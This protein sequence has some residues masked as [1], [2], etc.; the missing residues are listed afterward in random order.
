MAR[1]EMTERELLQSALR[2]LQRVGVPDSRA[3]SDTVSTSGGSRGGGS[4][5]SPMTDEQYKAAQKALKEKV[6]WSKGFWGSMKDAGGTALKVLSV[7]Q[8]AAFTGATKLGHAMDPHNVKD[9]SWKGMAGSFYDGYKGGAGVLD[10]YGVTNPKVLRWGGL[11]M[12][13]VADPMWLVGAGALSKIN[14]AKKAA[15][16][17]NVGRSAVKLDK[18][19]LYHDGDTLIRETL[20]PAH[21]GAAEQKADKLVLKF[22]T[23][24][25][26][27]T[28]PI[29]NLK[30]QKITPENSGKPGVFRKNRAEKGSYA[31]QRSAEEMGSF[32][33]GQ[34]PALRKHFNMTEQEAAK[35][36]MVASTGHTPTEQLLHVERA[37]KDGILPK[38]A[39]DAFE[40]VVK[41]GEEASAGRGYKSREA[42]I[43]EKNAEKANLQKTQYDPAT[44]KAERLK[45]ADAVSKLQSEIAGLVSSPFYMH[46]G[47]TREALEEAS[48]SAG[49]AKKLLHKVGRRGGAEKAASR[50][51]DVG[52]ARSQENMFNWLTRPQYEA[53]AKRLGLSADEAAWIADRAEAG[54]M[55]A[56]SEKTQPLLFSSKN[57]K[58]P[59][60]KNFMQRRT[61]AKVK[62]VRYTPEWDVFTQLTDGLASGYKRTAAQEIEKVLKAKGITTDHDAWRSIF[63]H[64]PTAVGDP[65]SLEN[66]V[67]APVQ[68]GVTALKG[69]YTTLNPGHWVNN[70][71]GDLK[72]S[73]INGNRR[74][75]APSAIPRGK[76]WKLANNRAGDKLESTLFTLPDGSKV[77]AHQLKAEAAAAGIGHGFVGG[78]VEPILRFMQEDRRNPMAFLGRMNTRRENAQRLGTFTKHR[79]AGDDMFEAAAKSRRVHFD[80]KDLTPFE[81][82]WMRN[83][84]LFY[85]WLKKNPFLQASGMATRPGLY[86]ATNSMERAREK[87]ANEPEY[88][89]RQGGIPTPFGTFLFQ[90]PANDLRK[91]NLSTD[92][93]RQ[94]IM[95][96]ITPPVRVPAE[97][98]LNKQ[99]F[100]GGDIQ[101][102]GRTSPNWLSRLS[103][104]LGLP[105][106]PLDDARST[107]LLAQGAGPIGGALNAATDSES[108]KNRWLDTLG[109]LAGVKVQQD[110][111]KKFAKMAQA[112]ANRKK[113]AATRARNEKGN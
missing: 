61:A 55:F 48:K 62:D 54:G 18:A 81:K 53:Q 22:G 90:D 64:S 94:S 12:D 5:K 56:K 82:K 83:S 73:W 71:L 14:A 88:F 106:G 49:A 103:E 1:G 112:E 60:P 10:A 37:I 65:A 50:V 69:V 80:Y 2:V 111:P 4:S 96:A 34:A 27:V 104:S 28:V 102:D 36:G 89:G 97:I 20:V 92:N 98:M 35:L 63:M 13:L 30:A 68:R 95:S 85:T 19:G 40:Y 42:L 24:N 78:E 66:F 39:A 8:A 59:S 93:A 72:N 107:Y 16:T 77:S 51:G 31:G 87:F 109:R 67:G 23:R 7:P 75:L 3:A 79:Q 25:H 84:V 21:M 113:A 45:A 26:S 44:P 57:A 6:G 9:A 47:A 70:F 105:A 38:Q 100:T 41:K 43:Q 99:F 58:A 101:R 74:H 11:G 33:R 76:Y 46:S 110:E 86:N 32:T 52:K 29:K 91:F 17:G 108:E 15:K